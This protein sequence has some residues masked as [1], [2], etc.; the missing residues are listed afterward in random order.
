MH[1]WVRELSIQYLALSVLTA[2]ICGGVSSYRRGNSGSESK[3]TLGSSEG[4]P[5]AQVCLPQALFIL[6]SGIL[7]GCPPLHP[8]LP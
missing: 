3:V 5:Q 6:F 4:H 8:I 7:A 2:T 1:V